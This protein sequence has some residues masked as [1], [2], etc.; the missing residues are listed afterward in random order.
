V[1]QVASLPFYLASIAG[2]LRNSGLARRDT[3]IAALA[4]PAVFVNLTHGQNGF[5][6]AGLFTGALLGLETHPWL[7]GMLLRSSP[8]NR[9]SG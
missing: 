3:L 5:L 7:A 1:W 6:T 9:S 4:F 8:T 2:V